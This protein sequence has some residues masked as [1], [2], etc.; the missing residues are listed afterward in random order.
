MGKSKNITV[1]YRY[2][3][4]LHMGL[5][6][7]PV[8]AISMI[9]AGG[10][11]LYNTPIT[12]SGQIGLNNAYLFGGDDKE[13]GIVG[14][15]WVCMGEQTQ[16]PNPLLQSLLGSPMPAFR[17]LVTLVFDGEVGSMSP[18]VKPWAFQ[19]QRFTAGWR[20]P[21]WQPALCQVGSGMNGAHF[22]YRAI[23]DPVTGLGRDPST[24]DL[25]KMQAAAQT[26][27]DE[28]MGLC[29]KWSRSDVLANFVDIVV[30]HVGGMFVDDPTTGLQYLKLLRGDYDITK[31]PVVDES[32]IV[33]LTSYEPAALAGS[34]NEITVTYHD[35]TTNTD[36]NVTVQNPVNILAQGRVVPQTNTYAGLWN[37]DQATRVAMRDLRASSS[38]PARM[39]M[40]VHSTLAVAKGDVLAFSWAKLNISGM[41]IRVLEID[42]GTPTANTIT[43]TCAQ[44]VY[45]LPDQAYVVVQ[46][47]LWSPPDVTPHPVPNQQL[48][49]AT[50]RDL[51][52]NLSAG[53]LAQVGALSGY[54]GVLAERPS[55]VAYNYDLWSRPGTSGNF[56][57]VSSGNFTPTATLATAMV[58]ELGPSV[59]AFTNPINLDQ[60]GVGTE[61]VIDGESM[62]LTAIDLV[63]NIVTLARGCVDTVPAIHAAGARMWFTDHFTGSDPTEYTSGET[64]QAKLLTRTSS[65]VL[66]ASVAPFTSVVLNERQIRP[67]PPGNLAIQGIAYPANIEGSLALTWSH[68][69]RLLQ[70]DQLID[71]T[72]GNIGPE[73]NTTY[74]VRV[75]LN[76][77]LDS[78]TTGI[79]G[80]AATPI[81][82]GDGTV[83]VQ[84]DAVRD[85]Y[86]SWQSLTATFSYVRGQMRLTEAGDTRITEAG[87]TR[88]LES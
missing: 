23:T 25:V 17:G 61:V 7:G 75:Y 51:S 86:T 44:D 20:T 30:G 77:T 39:K 18:Y 14:T 10:K 79:A 83:Q 74:T 68:R 59:V 27:H 5:C 47:P 15:L 11:V 40:K 19:V 28:G 9:V 38:L 78:T 67:Y 29:L 8:D 21:V 22:I 42:R 43:L 70:A 41:P 52:A 85:G 87:D 84:I 72:S 63:N 4:T 81:V 50:Y 88:I 64:V 13:G 53:D 49:E 60:I 82:S 56:A 26:L 1:G 2:Y 58:A 36:A 3:M 57:K 80:T 16:T 76:G 24:L 12:A 62:R 6:G 66:D 54:V 32:N 37:A 45:G 31:V 73:P 65:G 34:V 55:S 46:P 48:I 33:E 35:A 69:D 71:T